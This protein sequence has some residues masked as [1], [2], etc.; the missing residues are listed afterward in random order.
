MIS[1]NATYADEVVAQDTDTEA[2]VYPVIKPD[3]SI[4]SGYRFVNSKDSSRAEEYEYL[5]NSLLLSG[6]ARLFSFPHR[7]HL[8]ADFRNTKDYFGD[9]SYAY[10]DIVVFRGINRTLFH[11]LDNITLIDLDPSTVNPQG[12]MITRRDA[13]EQYGVKTGLSN[14]TLRLKTPDFPLH[15]YIDSSIVDKDGSMQQR[16]LGGS[17][18]FSTTGISPNNDSR[19]RI[20]QKRDI[21]WISR[22]ITVGLNSHL[23]PVEVDFS[24][25]EKRFSAGGNTVF[26]ENYLDNVSQGK[27]A[28]AA[29][30]Y[31]HNQISDLKGASNTLKL[32]TSYSGGLVASATLSKTDR[33]NRDSGAKADYFTGTGELSWIPSPKLAVF[34]K[35]RHKDTDVD[36]PEAVSISDRLNPLTN[37]YTYAVAPSIS[38]STDLVSAIVRYRL[39]TGVTLK[40]EYSFE[41]IRRENVEELNLPGN[42]QKNILSLSA[43]MRLFKRL[44]VK[45]K[46]THKEINNPFYNIEPDRADEGKISLAWIPV[47]GISTLLSYSTAQEKR[48]DMII[49]QVDTAKDRTVHRDRLMGS[50]T[51]AVLKNLSCTASYSYFHNKIAQDIAVGTIVDTEVP[52]RSMAQ[53]YAF[54][55]AYTPVL[56]ITLSGGISHTIGSGGYYPNNQ[57]LLQP[58]DIS[59][60]SKLKTRETV[61]TANGEYRLKGGFTTGLQYRYSDFK[62]VLDNPYD[63]TSN[64]RAHIV[65]LTLSKKW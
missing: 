14:L 25:G 42:T 23:G 3:I 10:E 22:E 38:S 46:Y 20:T 8:D 54:D 59:S 47:P 56:N 28:R 31:P 41:D 11:N 33:E 64:G 58:V 19:N 39:L 57:D 5:H 43:D 13:G 60:Y 35:Y 44:T 52:Y 4:T 9:M 16:F 49:P 48:S 40:G 63:D 18:G 36:N 55:I 62:D 7:F 1:V 65:L 6:E 15:F 17:G 24:H 61:V 30:E 53:S 2:Y 27:I 37:S 29:G 32:H 50:L 45:A 51:L 34:I 21:D 12:S 26:Y